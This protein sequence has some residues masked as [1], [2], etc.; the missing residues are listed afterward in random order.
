MVTGNERLHIFGSRI[1]EEDIVYSLGRP[2][3]VHKR[4]VWYLRC[5]MTIRKDKSIIINQ[6]MS[7]NV[8]I[9]NFIK[10]QMP[11]TWNSVR[12][13]PNERV[14]SFLCSIINTHISIR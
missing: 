12:E 14:L 9:D 6:L 10:F 1:Y 3:A 2:K 8:I 4:T 11:Q 7:R 13:Q 5:H